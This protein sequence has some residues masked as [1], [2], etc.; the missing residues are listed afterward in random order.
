MKRDFTAVLRGHILLAS[1]HFPE[2]AFASQ[3]DTLAR[4]PLWEIGCDFGHGTG[5]GVGFCLGVHEGPVAISPRSPAEDA[6]RVLSGLVVSN[7]PGLYRPGRW[8]VRIENLVTPVPAEPEIDQ[9]IPMMVFETLT[10]CPIDTRLVNTAMMTPF[11]IWWLNDYHR[12]VREA[13]SELVS[14][15]ALNWLKNATET[16]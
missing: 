9:M 13:L 8:G 3:L 14:E 16:I 12:R 11:E 5:H 7:E 15:K 1:T 2:G 6:S 4:M 10:L